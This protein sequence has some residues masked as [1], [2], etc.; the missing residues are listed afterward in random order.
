MMTNVFEDLYGEREK[1]TFALELAIQEVTK[2]KQHAAGE[3]EDMDEEAKQE[4]KAKKNAKSLKNKGFLGVHSTIKLP[5][6]IG[7]PEF[8]KHPFAGIVYCGLGS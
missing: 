8:E 3:A 7:T 1:I 5:F 6:V 2:T 4:A